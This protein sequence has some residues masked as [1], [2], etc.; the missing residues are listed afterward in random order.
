MNPHESCRNGAA[1]LRQIVADQLA[2]L[3]ND[4]ICHALG[5]LQTPPSRR[6]MQRTAVA[7]THVMDAIH[8]AA[9][10]RLIEEAERRRQMIER[11]D[12]N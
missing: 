1:Q 4:E 2:R 7:P 5:V 10:I 11:A 6:A 12:M 3:S 9:L 8:S